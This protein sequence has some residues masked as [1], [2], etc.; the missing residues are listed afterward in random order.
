MNLW[1]KIA[2]LFAVAVSLP[3][4]TIVNDA[5]NDYLA[6]WTAGTNPNGV[7][8]YGWSLTP[9]GVLTPFTTH[10]AG[11]GFPA[12][13]DPWYDLNNFTSLTPS[14]VLNAGPLF[15]DG[16]IDN[17]PA[18]ALALHGGGSAA[19]CGGIAGACFAEV[20]WTAPVTGLFTL[21]ATFTGREFNMATQPGSFAIV[22]PSGTIIF[23]GTILDQQSRS[24]TGGISVNA[25]DTFTFAVRSS[26]GLVGDETQLAA[27][28]TQV[29]SVPEPSTFG[30]L[31]ASL[32]WIG[33]RLRRR[34]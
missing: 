12:Q 6:G 22:D 7:W 9:G 1:L 25:G 4:T 11:G 14:M 24:L 29:N 27:T 19:S 17:L 10:V 2:I 18:G 20:V 8:S 5:A 15:I 30:L 33:Y 13:F 31:F 26:V 3:A 21:S 16:N 32:G 28:F 23:N 34:A